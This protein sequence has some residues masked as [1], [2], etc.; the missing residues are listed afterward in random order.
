MT[1]FTDCQ[2]EYPGRPRPL[3]ARQDRDYCAAFVLDIE[4]IR[5][6]SAPLRGALRLARVAMAAG[7][8]AA[9]QNAMGEIAEAAK[10]LQSVEA[11]AA[12]AERRIAI[13]RRRDTR[14]RT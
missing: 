6:L 11:V 8:P 14:V 3:R 5:T 4:R 1:N 9:L 2:D 12:L 7:D 10:A 13:H